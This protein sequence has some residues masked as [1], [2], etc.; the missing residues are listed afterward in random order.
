MCTAG[1]DEEGNWVRIYPIPYRKLDYELQYQKYQWIELD[2]IKN[3]SDFRPETF[4]PKNVDDAE[5][6]TLLEKIDTR[7]N[8]ARRKELVL[9]NVYT[10][11]NQLINNAKT[12]GK[13]T[14]LAVFKPTIIK[15]FKYVKAARE[16]NTKQQGVLAQC[17]LFED[18]STKEV[19][20]KLPFTFFYIFE[21]E[22]GNESQMM[23]EDWELGALFW[24]CFKKHNGDQVKAC[25]DVKRKY[26]DEFVMTKDLYF[27]LGT[28][29]RHHLK[30]RNPFIIIGTFYPQK[31]KQLKLDL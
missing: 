10:D 20:R 22:N 17:N 19:V 6:I 23:N 4:K 12:Q 1:F 2:L 28:T 15:N 9:Q 11:M 8:W 31:E 27:F 7:S 24:N 16:W 14:S 25:E 13:W 5:S 26:L 21:D 3:T 30:S 18:K 29:K